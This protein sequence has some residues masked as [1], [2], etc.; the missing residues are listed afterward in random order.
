[1]PPPSFPPPSHHYS[2]LNPDQQSV[3]SMT[4]ATGTSGHHRPQSL[5]WDPSQQS[6]Q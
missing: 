1:M 2:N 5:Y 6:Y 4:Y 3:T